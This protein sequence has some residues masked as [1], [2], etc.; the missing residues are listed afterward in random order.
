M[1]SRGSFPAGLLALGHYH[2]LNSASPGEPND[3]EVAEDLMRTCYEMYRRTPTGLAPELVYFE[4][5]EAAH[6]HSEAAS[7]DNSGGGDFM[8][9]AF[10]SFCDRIPTCRDRLPINACTEPDVLMAY[11]LYSR[12]AVRACTRLKLPASKQFRAKSFHTPNYSSKV[13]GLNL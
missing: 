6:A 10:V 8:I 12:H 5:S 11:G 2:G 9:K 3:L 13:S 1:R 4:T 7:A